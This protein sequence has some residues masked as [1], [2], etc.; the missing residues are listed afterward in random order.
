[1][2]KTRTWFVREL[3][4][5]MEDE[6]VRVNEIAHHCQISRDRINNYLQG[7]SLPNPLILAKMADFLG[8]TINDLLDF[9]EADE[10]ELVGYEPSSMF[11]DEDEFMIH[12]R[13]RLERYMIDS[14]ISIADL[15]EKS[16]IDKHTIKYWL[17]MLK[18]QPTLIRTS[19]L[20]RICDA[21]KCTPS[22]LLGY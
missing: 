19:D 20:L 3:S 7:R 22:D 10:D 1:M 6:Q 13:N 2:E 14:D 21:L 4:E 18:R 5:R 8:C 17:C 9:D 16:G 15:S 12:I 11:E